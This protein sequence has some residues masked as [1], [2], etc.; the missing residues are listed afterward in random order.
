MAEQQG[1]LLDLQTSMFYTDP[2]SLRV[3]HGQKGEDGQL[4][5]GSIRDVLTIN[6]KQN[7]EFDRTDIQGALDQYTPEIAKY[8]FISTATGFRVQNCSG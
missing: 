8:E 1:G 2:V 3:Y 4:V 6:N 5:Q 7:S